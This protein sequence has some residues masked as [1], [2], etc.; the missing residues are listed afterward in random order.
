M[1]RRSGSTTTS[2]KSTSR[3]AGTQTAPPQSTSQHTPSRRGMAG[4]LMGG[5]MSGMAFGAGAEFF[6]QLFRNPVIGGFMMPLIVSGLTAFGSN[7]FLLKPGPYRTY[8]T[9]GIFAGTFLLSKRL[10]D[11]REET[12]F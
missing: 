10:F 6:R 11:Q 8:Y 2:Q 9:A 5:L 3:T 1:P 12:N 7:R 4:G